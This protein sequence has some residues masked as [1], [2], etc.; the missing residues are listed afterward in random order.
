MIEFFPILV[1]FNIDY[2]V[3]PFFFCMK[4]NRLFSC[5]SSI[6]KILECNPHYCLIEVWS[7]EFEDPISSI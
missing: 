4:M 7:F 2:I 3:V 5:Y 1:S 6:G